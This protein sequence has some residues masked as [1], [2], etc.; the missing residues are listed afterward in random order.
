MSAILQLAN[1]GAERAGAQVL[2]DVSLALEAG[3]VVALLGPNGAGKTTLVDAVCGLATKRGGTV[4]FADRDITRVKPYDIARAGLVQVPQD[5]DLFSGLTVEENIGLGIEACGRDRSRAMT[6]DEV[7]G[8]FP[9]LGERWRQRA[10]SLSGG[11]QQM[12]AIGRALVSRPKVLLLDEPSSGLAPRVVEEIGEFLRGL[13]QSGLTL[14]LVEQAID[15]ALDL[16]ERFV[17]LRDG[18]IAFDGRIDE[19]GSDPSAFILEQYL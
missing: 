8:L 13:T 6:L 16:C 19:M 2:T 9:R 11:E 4:H 10:G 5:R 1:L 7:A 3:E 14:L 17:I 15:V 12:V 18:H